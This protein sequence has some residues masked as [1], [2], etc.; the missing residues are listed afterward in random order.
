MIRRP[1]R[2]TLFPY[3]TLFRSAKNNFLVLGYANVNTGLDDSDE[4]NFAKKSVKI[5]HDILLISDF[6]EQFVIAYEEID[7]KQRYYSPKLAI[8]YWS[9]EILEA[10]QTMLERHLNRF[11]EDDE[12]RNAFYYIIRWFTPTDSGIAD[13]HQHKKVYDLRVFVETTIGLPTIINYT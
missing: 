4:F 11:T 6:I 3:T 5:L 12:S 10:I 7:G 8:Y 2:S 13:P 9:R 1:P